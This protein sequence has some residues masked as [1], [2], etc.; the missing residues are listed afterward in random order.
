MNPLLL[1]CFLDTANLPERALFRGCSPQPRRGLKSER[2]EISLGDEGLK[3]SFI[4]VVKNKLVFDSVTEKLSHVPQSIYLLAV[5]I[6]E[7]F[8]FIRFFALV[9]PNI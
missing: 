7:V 2:I 9:A 1:L 3:N 6:Q 4:P 5:V 8:Y